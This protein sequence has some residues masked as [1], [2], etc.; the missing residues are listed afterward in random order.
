LKAGERVVTDGQLRLTPGARIEIKPAT[1]SVN[2]Q[3]S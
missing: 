3:G 2:A 1:G